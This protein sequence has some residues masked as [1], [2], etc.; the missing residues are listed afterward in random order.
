[1]NPLQILALDPSSD[2]ARSLPAQGLD[3]I[4]DAF[5]K[6]LQHAFV[7]AI[8][9]AGVAFLVSLP[10]PWFRYHK[11]NVIDPTKGVEVQEEKTVTEL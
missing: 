5:V 3:G 2:A 6:A 7:L 4:L 11:V 9:V 8:P 1:M 10:Q